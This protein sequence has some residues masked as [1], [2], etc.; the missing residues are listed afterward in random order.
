MMPPL[1]FSSSAMRLTMT[2]SCNGRIL[3]AMIGNS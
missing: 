1:V 2:R 3:V